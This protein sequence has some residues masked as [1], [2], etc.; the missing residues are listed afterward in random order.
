MIESTLDGARVAVAVP[1]AFNG[2]LLLWNRTPLH[3]STPDEPVELAANPILAEHLLADGYAL[4]ASNY[5]QPA[6]GAF[7]EALADGERLLSHVHDTLAPERVIAW[8]GSGG[9]LLATLLSERGLVDGAVPL[10]GAFD[11]PAGILDRALGYAQILTGRLGSDIPV[12]GIT[13]PEETLAAVRELIGRATPMALAEASAAAEVPP[14]FEAL[15]PRPAEPDDVHAALVKYGTVGIATFWATLRADIEKRLGGNPSST[16]P[17][18]AGVPSLEADPGVRAELDKM[19]PTGAVLAPVLAL[20][21][22]GDG[23][24]PVGGLARYLSRADRQLVRA[25]YASRGGHVCFT[26]A[27]IRAVLRALTQRLDTGVWP[28]LT[29]AEM[30]RRAAEEDDALQMAPD[31]GATWRPVPAVP[32]FI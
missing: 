16:P 3:L 23:L 29:P 20:H 4:A 21:S 15:N 14:W 17:W 28:D 6:G 31:W 32:A 5:T 13:E 25:V 12:T 7:A 26:F 9:G 27:E 30:L 1:D 24:T 8:G 19:T 10:G 22:T 2:T 11:G 18:V